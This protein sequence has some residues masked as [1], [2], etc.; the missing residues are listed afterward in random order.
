LLE[1]P[2]RTGGEDEGVG[3]HEATVGLVRASHALESPGSG[4]ASERRG[5]EPV[6]RRPAAERRAGGAVKSRCVVARQRSGR[7]RRSAS[8]PALARRAYP[9]HAM[10]HSLARVFVHVVWTTW[11]RTP[12]IDRAAEACVRRMVGAQGERLGCPVRAFG[13][14][15]DHVHLLVELDRR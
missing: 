15:D 11:A 7:A 13:A 9:L 12:W 2:G 3:G 8:V 4:A 5:E 6:R 1:A 10:S 14:W